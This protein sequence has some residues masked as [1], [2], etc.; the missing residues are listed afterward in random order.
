MSGTSRSQ[1]RAS[2]FG[3]IALC[4]VV[5]SCALPIASIAAQPSVVAAPS[6]DET[7]NLLQQERFAELDKRF[8]AV[9]RAYRSGIASD[10]D[11]RAAFRVFYDT[12]ATLLLKY[13]LWVSQSP[14]SY[15]AHLARGIYYASVGD[16]LDRRDPVTDTVERSQAAFA[17]YDKAKADLDV[18]L[19]LDPKPLLSYMHA[20]T[21]SRAHGNL[22]ESRR[23]L[24]QAILIDPHN[25]IARVKYM[26]VIETRWH[27]NQE[28]MKSFLEEC[29]KATLS[30][31]HM[32][33]LE[34][35]I[36]EDEGW[37][38][39]VV[40]Q[41]Y[42]AAEA[43][44]RRSEELGGTI[45]FSNLA[46]VLMKQHKYREA[47]EPLTELLSSELPINSTHYFD[48]LG[49]L[50]MAYIESGRAREGLAALVTA[51]RSGSPFAQNE[52]G[53]RYMM[54]IAGVLPADPRA[55][56]EWFRKAAG[57][58]LPEGKLNYD[59]ARKLLGE[60]T[61]YV[62]TWRGPVARSICDA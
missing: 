16:A 21:I 22:H 3:A 44:Y 13:D 52:L 15:V 51:A 31:V 9:Q 5:C 33:I 60:P 30:Q 26:T 56:L 12:S 25:Y 49:S 47:I 55:G 61:P 6:A 18:S 57:Q 10:E 24:D 27:G 45:S 32:Q 7:W 34:S 37:I 35:V 28:L 4:V 19:A 36:A 42:A 11:L 39:Q 58:G 59:R 54:G 53:R 46:D 23:L 17:A 48:V 38:H 40:D 41:D 43:A 14:K 29:R 50:G 20:M 62:P 1:P 2:S 8:S